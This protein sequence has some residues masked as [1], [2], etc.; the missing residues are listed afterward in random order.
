MEIK[1][2]VSVDNK[3]MQILLGNCLFPVFCVLKSLLQQQRRLLPAYSPYVFASN[4][5]VAKSQR[6]EKRRD[7]GV[8]HRLVRQFF[9][10]KK[11]N[12]R[13]NKQQQTH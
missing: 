1:H 6:K 4:T 11:Q 13:L 2:I 5:N 8:I 9:K 10:G 3:K 7:M 12:N